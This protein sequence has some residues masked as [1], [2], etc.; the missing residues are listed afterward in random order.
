MAINCHTTSPTQAFS[1]DP[2]L[3]NNAAVLPVTVNPPSDHPPY[4]VD[5]HGEV[6]DGGRAVECQITLKASLS[7]A[8]N[9]QLDIQ[10]KD[11]LLDAA[12]TL[13]FAVRLM[14]SSRT[15]PPA[16]RR[17]K[18]KCSMATTKSNYYP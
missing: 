1:V 2:S 3:T 13:R 6:S 8:P 17:R 5:S 16:K 7:S 18:D 15:V 10:V 12:G 4:E 11:Y 14:C 9:G